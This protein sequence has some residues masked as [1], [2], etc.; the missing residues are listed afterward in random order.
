[1]DKFLDRADFEYCEMDTDSAY[2]ALSGDNIEALVRN[3][4]A[5]NL[6]GSQGTMKKSK[7]SI[8]ARTP[9][10]FKTEFLGDRIT[11]LNSKMYFCFNDSKAKFFC[12][13]VNKYTN[14]ITKDTYLNVIQTKTIG[15]ATNRG[16]RVRENKACTYTQ[17]ENAFTY[18]YGKRKVLADGVSTTYLDI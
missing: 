14:A 1:M 5:K 3:M 7:L 8:S 16:F 17:A 9:G 15:R 13:G 12:K 18:F 6:I 10:L 4:N 11:G 2:V